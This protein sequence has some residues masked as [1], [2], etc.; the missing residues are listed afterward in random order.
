MLLGNFSTIHNLSPSRLTSMPYI[1]R[2][3]MRYTHTPTHNTIQ[4]A[5][6]HWERI[7]NAYDGVHII[8]YCIVWYKIRTTKL[9]DH[10]QFTTTQWA[11]RQQLNEWM[12]H[13]LLCARIA[14]EWNMMTQTQ[15]TEYKW[16]KNIVTYRLHRSTKMTSLCATHLV[17]P[18]SW[19]VFFSRELSNFAQIVKCINI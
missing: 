16:L 1:W 9:S 11:R 15:N 3:N 2:R 18:F 4:Y 7:T 5:R 8:S 19:K 6:T 14:N 17:R 10:L 12:L 13:I